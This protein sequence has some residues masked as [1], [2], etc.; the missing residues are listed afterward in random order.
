MSAQRTCLSNG[1]TVP[2]G[3]CRVSSRHVYSVG[4]PLNQLLDILPAINAFGRLGLLPSSLLGRQDFRG[5]K[6]TRKDP[7]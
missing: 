1:I 2:P 3:P 6:K 7:L 5:L 4:I